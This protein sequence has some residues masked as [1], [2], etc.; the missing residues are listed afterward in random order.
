MERDCTIKIEQAIV[1]TNEGQSDFAA[2]TKKLEPKQT[3]LKSTSD[4]IE[5]LK[6]Q[7]SNQEDKLNDESRQLAKADRN[8]TEGV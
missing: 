7:F 6:K 5:G 2:L 4:E 3:E 8:Q 1:A